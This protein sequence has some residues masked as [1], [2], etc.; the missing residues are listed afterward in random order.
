MLIDKTANRVDSDRFHAWYPE[1]CIQQ[2]EV[3]NKEQL[4]KF[5]IPTKTHLM[6]LKIALHFHGTQ[7]L[8][9]YASVTPLLQVD[10]K[11]FIIFH[12]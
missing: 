3:K 2:N 7:D 9:M 11:I 12:I 10:T 8:T 5:M 1:Q 6:N 4:I